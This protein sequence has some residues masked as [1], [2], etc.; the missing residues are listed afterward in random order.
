VPQGE[1]RFNRPVSQWPIM[2]VCRVC[3]KY[4][5]LTPDRVNMVEGRAF[6]QCQLCG[7]AFLIRW[8]DAKALRDRQ[9]PAT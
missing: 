5:E 7:G 3:W 1:R 9:T 2:A 6:Y 8:E 4:I